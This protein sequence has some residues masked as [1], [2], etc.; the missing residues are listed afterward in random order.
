MAGPQGAEVPPIAIV[1]PVDVDASSSD[2]P[3]SRSPARSSSR[4]DRSRLML[5]VVVAQDREL[6][7]AGLQSAEHRLDPVDR[8]VVL[9]EVAGDDEQVGAPAAAGVDDRLEE[10]PLEAGG[11]VE[12]AE[13]DDL[14]AVERRGQVRD[15]HVPLAEAQP[16]RL[17]AAAAAAARNAGRRRSSASAPSARPGRA[18]ATSR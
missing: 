12:V 11:E 13:L 3:A 10:L 5:V 17:V 14:Q 16:E 2:L 1:D 15:R 9:D 4:D 7:Q 6:A 8:V 18:S